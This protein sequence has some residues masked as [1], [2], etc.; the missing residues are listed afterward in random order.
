MLSK[1]SAKY[2]S[3]RTAIHDQGTSANFN[4]AQKDIFV[5]G[6]ETVKKE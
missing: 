4:E 1:F 5:I 2:V 3:K 6:T